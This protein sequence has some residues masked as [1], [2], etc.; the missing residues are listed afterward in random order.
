MVSWL[1]E[2]SSGNESR[3]RKEKMMK[4]LKRVFQT[5]AI[6]SHLKKKIIKQLKEEMLPSCLLNKSLKVKKEEKKPTSLSAKV[7]FAS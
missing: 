7:L 2:I 6:R 3:S 4:L 1:Q 5:L